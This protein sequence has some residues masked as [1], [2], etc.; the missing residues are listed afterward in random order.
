MGK[1]LF[2]SIFKAT[3]QLSQSDILIV[4]TLMAL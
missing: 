2:G 1:G 4:L 3:E